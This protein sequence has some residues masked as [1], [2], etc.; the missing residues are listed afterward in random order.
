MVAWIPSA[1]TINAV[2]VSAAAVST[3]SAETSWR[4]LM[5]VR[6][7]NTATIAAAARLIIPVTAAPRIIPSCGSTRNGQA[8]PPISAPR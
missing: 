6:S 7:R 5:M 8:R 1:A 2:R 3:A 4:R